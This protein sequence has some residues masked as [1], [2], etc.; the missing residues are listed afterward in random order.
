M[1]KAHAPKTSNF[2][3]PSFRKRIDHSIQNTLHGQLYVLFFH[4][5]LLLP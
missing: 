1:M 3:P 4:V 5:N 2:N